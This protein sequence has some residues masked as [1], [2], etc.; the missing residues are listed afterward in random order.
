MAEGGG[1]VTKSSEKIKQEITCALCLDILEQPRILPCHH[2]YCK[3][4]LEGLALQNGGWTIPCPECRHV[5]QLPGNNVANL[6]TAF[7]INR[8]KEIYFSMDLETKPTTNDQHEETDGAGDEIEQKSVPCPKHRSQTLDLYCKTCKKLVCRDCIIFDRFHAEH[9]YTRV[10]N[11][12]TEYKESLIRDLEPLQNFQAEISLAIQKSTAV[13]EEIVSQQERN[14]EAVTKAFDDLTAVVQEQKTVLLSELHQATKG[15]TTV[16]SAQ[17]EKL[18]HADTELGSVLSSTLSVAE[19]LGHR[20]FLSRLEGMQQEIKSLGRR[21]QTL[22]LVPI[23]NPDII[24]CI[25]N[26]S[27]VSDLCEKQSRVYFLDASQCTASGDGLEVAETD[28]PSQFQVYVTDPDGNPCAVTQDVGAQLVS[29]RDGTVT[30]VN[31]QP[32]SPAF[33]LATYTPRVR[34]RYDLSVYVSHAQISG[35]P[36]RVMVHQPLSKLL[37][38]VNTINVQEPVGL[39]INPNGHLLIG[40]VGSG[41]QLHN[42]EVFDGNHHIDSFSVNG[43]PNELTTDHDGNIY[44]TDVVNHQLHKL[45]KDGECVKTVGGQGKKRGEFNF[46]NGLAFDSRGM[47]LVCDSNNNRIQVFDQNLKLV[48]T[49]GKEGSKDGQFQFPNNICI[50]S[51]GNLYISD[52]FNSRIQV[53]SKDGKHVRTLNLAVKPNCMFMKDELIYFS[54]CEECLHVLHCTS[55]EKLATFGRKHLVDPQGVVVDEDGFVYV[56]DYGHNRVLMF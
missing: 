31:V 14:V 40:S 42:I 44:T 55:G 8:L 49:I 41:L 20:D 24:I 50:D 46:P 18:R 2:V 10:E 43:Q 39:T 27:E 3:D 12:A 28:E 6:P 32:S 56:S 33:Y 51:T 16:I 47:L 13:K 29:V 19:S 22:P 1:A 53:L 38:P 48:K 23:E 11:A 30:T 52:S 25:P 7:H 9:N 5:V 4:C 35:S 26:V 17:Q 37:A 54:D 45:T 34:G 21:L 15:K 36:F